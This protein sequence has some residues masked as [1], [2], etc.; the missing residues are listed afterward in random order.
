MLAGQVLKV[1]FLPYIGMDLVKLVVAAII[2]K[3]V[4]N[5][6]ISARRAGGL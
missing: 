3:G 2:A 1:V 5:R 6:L 4:G